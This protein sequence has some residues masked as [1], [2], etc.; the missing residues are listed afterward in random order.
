MEPV[1]ELTEIEPGILLVK[2]QDRASGNAFSEGL[3]LGLLE[4]FGKI[5]ANE[6]CKAVVLTGYDSYF[7]TGGTREGLLSLHE[8]KG[9][10]T[11]TNIYSLALDCPVPVIAAM[12]GHGIGGGLVMGLFADLIVLSRESVYTTNFMNYGFTPGMG[13]TSIVPKKLGLVLAEEMLF[14]ARTYRGEEL[15][16]RGVSFPVLPRSEVLPHAIEMA[17]SLAE[18][19]RISLVALKNLLVDPIRETLPIIVKKEQAMHDKTFHLHA[20]KEN[21]EARFRNTA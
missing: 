17:R 16:Q 3:T 18:K 9:S 15:K 7:A 13:A 19:P 10:F 12:Q 20:V 4:T 11:D 21:I 1:V 14:L 6:A 5:G 8:G 2:M